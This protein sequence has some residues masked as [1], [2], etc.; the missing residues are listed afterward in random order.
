MPRNG[1]N[2]SAAPFPDGIRQMATSGGGPSP[3]PEV[4]I[5]HRLSF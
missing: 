3:T 5:E 2:C 1:K 4:Y